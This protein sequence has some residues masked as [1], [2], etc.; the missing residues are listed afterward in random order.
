MINVFVVGNSAVLE[1]ST[2]GSATTD[3][4]GFRE[5][6]ALWTR[7]RMSTRYADG[8]LGDWPAHSEIPLRNWPTRYVSTCDLR[9]SYWYMFVGICGG[10]YRLRYRSMRASKHV[11]FACL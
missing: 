5:R 10:A 6:T 9:G 7:R 3:S 11:S 1:P 8:R 4:A 2:T